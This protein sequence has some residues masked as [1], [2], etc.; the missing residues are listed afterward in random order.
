MIYTE[1]LDRAMIT[2]S[3]LGEEGALEVASMIIL[4]VATKIGD[5]LSL[6]GAEAQ[7]V[8]VELIE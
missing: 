1:D 6:K 8:G 5:D 3:K 7:V 2:I 4:G